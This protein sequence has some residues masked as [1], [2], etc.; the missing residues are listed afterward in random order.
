MGSSTRTRGSKPKLVRPKFSIDVSES[1]RPFCTITMGKTSVSAL[2]D[3]GADKSIM[4]SDLYKQLT[5][6]CIVTK[7]MGRDYDEDC[8]S[9]SGGTL[10]CVGKAKIKFKIGPTEFRHKFLI[11]ESLTKPLIIG[12]DYLDLYQGAIDY[13][14]QAVRIG[15]KYHPINTNKSPTYLIE[16]CKRTKLNGQS[17][18]MTPAQSRSKIKKGIYL[19]SQMGVTDELKDQPG[20]AIPDKIVKINHKGKCVIP[21]FNETPVQFL[22]HHAQCCAPHNRYN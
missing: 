18:T 11:M 19:L 21:I 14:A 15:R 4:S 10:K 8:T 2:F 7:E 13:E 17:I 20:L 22:L 16:T 9:A 5:D 6:D 12:S 1:K 3:S